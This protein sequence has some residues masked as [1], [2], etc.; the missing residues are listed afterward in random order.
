[1][2]MALLHL[3]TSLARW[4]AL[5][6]AALGL[7]VIFRRNTFWFGIWPEAGAAVAVGAF[8]MSLIG[9]GL[10]AWSAARTDVYRVREQT[11]SSARRGTTLELYRFAATLGWQVAAYLVVAFVAAFFVVRDGSPPGFR[12]FVGYV[13]L[14]AFLVV[15]ANG[16]GWLVGRLLNPTVAALTALF[17]WFLVVSLVGDPAEATPVSGPPWVTVEFGSVALRLGIALVFC[18]AVCA[19]AP[20]TAPRPVRLRRTALAAVALVAVGATLS[21]TSA[22]GHRAPVADPVCVEGAMTYCLWP[23]DE[24]YVPMVRA[25]DARVAALPLALELPDKMVD[26][27]LSG[28]TR[29]VSDDLEVELPGDFPPEFDISE[30]SQWALARG[31]S[32]AIVASEFSQCDLDAPVDPDFRWEQLR[33]WLEYR[34]A[35]GGSRDYTTDAPEEFQKAWAQG[36]RAAAELSDAEQADW[37]RELI[38]T[39]NDRYCHV[40]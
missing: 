30:G 21:S 10:A 5:P 27:S 35:G 36:Y 3:R 20:R 13:G 26:Y 12:W 31:V 33:A 22:L 29:W 24:K 37:A 32:V 38:A 25:V 11:S 17:S 2:R 4:A 7:V 16:W 14:G 40:V 6:L 18:V 39:T 8:F 15:M 1:M 9:A 34:L 19:L 28:S 23:E